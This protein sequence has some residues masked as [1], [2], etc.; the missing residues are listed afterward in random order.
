MSTK[1]IIISL[2]LASIPSLSFGGWSGPQEVITG[3]WGSGAGQFDFDAGDTTDFFP[4]EFGVDKDGHVVIPDEGNKRIVIY[5]SNGTIKNTLYKPSSLPDLDNSAGWPSGFILYTG[6]NSFAIDCDYQKTSGRGRRP[7]KICLI[8]YNSNILS[9]LDAAQ[10]F[11]VETGY[12]LLKNNIYSLYSPTGILIKTSAE[13]LLELGVVSERPI[14]ES[15]YKLTIKYPDKTYELTTGGTFMRYVRDMK[16]YVYGVNDDSL[17]K[18]DQCGKQVG[19]L[20]MPENQTETVTSKT[21]KSLAIPVEYGQPVIA[22]S[23]DVYTWKKTA[24]KYSIVKWTWQDE[25]TVPSGPDAPTGLTVTPSTT[26]LYLAWTASAQDPGCVTGYEIARATTSG[27]VYSTIGTVNK[28]VVKYNDTS[29]EVGTMYYYKVRAKAGSEY[30]P[31]T[32]EVSGKR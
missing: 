12:V 4:K 25:S 7:F 21:G 19:E 9:K 24:F 17:W 32:A 2:L 23:G 26:G 18:F 30:S 31:Y 28:G 22:P 16:G 20:L 1:K 6:G 29:A 5:N 3:T 10:V 13:R 27:G 8:D 15:Q 11:P 14:S